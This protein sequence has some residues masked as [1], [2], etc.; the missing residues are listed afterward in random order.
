MNL[1]LQSNA[2]P[3]DLLTGNNGTEPKRK[4]G[5]YPWNEP[6]NSLTFPELRYCIS[7]RCF[8]V[9]L[10]FEIEISALLCE[11]W[12]LL[13]FGNKTYCRILGLDQRPL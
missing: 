13:T 5:L 10:S 4:T 2:L 8:I 11:T 7:V 3:T 1:D 6:D 12:L 9:F